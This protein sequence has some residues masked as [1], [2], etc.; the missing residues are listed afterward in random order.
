MATILV[1]FDTL[2]AGFERL[3]QAHTLIRPP[4]GR[5]FTPEELRELIP[6]AD[7]LCSVF[8][9]PIPAELIALGKRLRLIANY[10]VGYNNIDIEYARTHGIT[11]TNT[12][13]SVIVPTAEL[14][15][16]LLLDC[17]RRVSELDRLVRREPGVKV[18]LS[19]ID[20]LGWLL[21][22]K[23]IGIVGYGNIGEAVAERCRAFG[24]QVLYYKRHRLAPEVEQAKELTYRPLEDIL[25]ESDVITLHTPYSPATHHL[26][27][28]RELALMPRHAI[29]INTARGAVVDEAALVEALRS[30]QIAAAGLDVFEHNDLPLPALSELDNVV[31]TPH[32]GTQTRDSRLM[33]T[34][35]MTENVLRFLEGRTDISRVV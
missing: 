35:E 8:D 16:A 5:D 23:R 14:A 15:L 33:M 19:R 34:A 9:I 32:V 11:V 18:S 2:E 30:G 25:R 17:A 22:G 4:L 28:A 26:I 1:A 7:V 24:M 6:E 21:Q 3:S 12:P 29:L 13:H 31:M 20:R 10:A 27:G